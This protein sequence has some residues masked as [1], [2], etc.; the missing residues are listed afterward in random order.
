MTRISP[1]EL[2][3]QPLDKVPFDF[4]QGFSCGNP[5]IDDFLKTHYCALRDHLS[6]IASTSVI[7][8][9]NNVV[10]FFTASCTQVEIPEEES[11]QLGIHNLYVPAIEVKFLAVSKGHQRRGIGTIILSLIV[12]EVYKLSAM[13]ACRYIFLWAVPEERALKLYTD[14]YFIDTGTRNADG[15]HLMMF[16][17][18]NDLEDEEY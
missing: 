18:P 12:S 15:S 16:Q 1:S 9:E 17:L 5:L 8:F 10:A 3:I 11:K 7:L 14:H 13:F 2:T 4:V 6:G